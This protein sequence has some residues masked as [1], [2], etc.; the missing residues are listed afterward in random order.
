VALAKSPSDR[1]TRLLQGRIQLEAADSA[2]AIRT[3]EALVEEEGSDATSHYW[4]AQSYLRAGRS[5]AAK[6]E[7]ERAIAA[8]PD[9]AQAI[10][11]LADMHTRDGTPQTGVELLNELIAK[12][13]RLV[14]AYR[15]L[16]S[17]Y[18][19]MDD[20]ARA[21]RAF[22]KFASMSP[23]DARG[24][25]TIGVVLQRQGKLDEARRYL[26]SA[27]RRE[28][29]WMEALLQLVS[30]D[31]AQGQADA[32]MERV[33]PY[34]AR[35]SNS[36]TLQKLLG[37]IH[38]NQG[39]LGSAE[40][41]YQQALELEPDS[42]SAR[43]SLAQ[44]YADS[45]RF[46]EAISVLS[47][48]L[49]VEPENA[50]ALMLSGSTYERMH[51]TAHAIAAYQHVLEIRPNFAPAANNLAYIYAEHENR[52]D[53]ALELAQLALQSDPDNPQIADTL[54]WIH[55]R[56]GDFDD[57]VSLLEHSAGELPEL[58]EVHFHLGMAY[59]KLGNLQSARISLQ[60]ALELDSDF[61]GAEEAQRVLTELR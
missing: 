22:R 40:S 2:A 39:E 8:D 38:A 3:F 56:R 19:G 60:R 20:S 18:L 50:T 7:L 6:S 41:A 5:D 23:Q 35:D 29:G 16:G 51:K 52:L 61:R 11:T 13:P 42:T 12:Q 33:R 21:L 30:L 27:H 49:E 59:F 9:L 47:Q 14:E 43:M 32:A 4:L 10:I 48:A 54:G 57:A 26:E 28:P 46:E 25:Y 36:A 17:A 53:E 58:A 34:L 15:A 1:E 37:D 55:Y 31:L 44:F 45:E 24:P